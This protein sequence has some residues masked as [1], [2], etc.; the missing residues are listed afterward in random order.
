MTRMTRPQ[1]SLPALLTFLGALRASGGCSIADWQADAA[2]GCMGYASGTCQALARCGDLFLAPYGSYEACEQQLSEGCTYS[3]G[4]PDVSGTGAGA[5]L[6]G[7]M[8]QSIDCDALA[9]AELPPGCQSPSG[10]RSEGAPCQIGAQCASARC[11]E[12]DGAWGVCRERGDVGSACLAQADCGKGLICSTKGACV[13]LGRAGEAC[14]IGLPCRAPLACVAGLCA[15]VAIG[16]TCQVFADTLCARLAACSSALLRSTYGDLHTCTTRNAFS[17]RSSLGM[18]EGLGV[19]AGV[20]GCTRALDAASCSEL[21]DHALPVACQLVPGVLADGHACS[22][23][24]QCVSTRCAR[25]AGAACGVCAPLATASEACAAD[26]D[27][28][29]GL[30]CS[31]GSCRVPSGLGA[32]CDAAQRCTQ[33]Y[34]CAAGS[35]ME[36]LK[37]GAPCTLGADRCDH[38]A[39]L[40][41]GGASTCE[42]WLSGS[43][44]EACNQTKN[45]WAACSGGSSCGP[46]SEGDTCLG[47][48]PDG[49]PCTAD[50]PPYCLAPAHC[51]G[52]VCALPSSVNCP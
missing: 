20:A 6:C 13:V 42:P 26:S 18:T 33:P 9:N 2:N 40:M 35:C 39:G 22:T 30:I 46:T 15:A 1:H 7:E 17:C 4:L 38:N 50:R 48:L 5:A 31:G 28:A 52:G 11:A 12:F 23:D 34:V 29:V 45:G 10:K 32:S 51:L 43:A 37:L 14:G 44:G 19:S 24:S 27:C 47:P 25:S 8:M 3:F 21:L 49:S 41:C 16:P 36:A